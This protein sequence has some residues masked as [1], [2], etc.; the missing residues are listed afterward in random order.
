MRRRVVAIAVPAILAACG[1]PRAPA[2]PPVAI[3][4][5]ILRVESFLPRAADAAGV[6][7]AVQGLVENPNPFELSLGRIGYAFQVEGRPAGSGL[8]STSVVL[9]ARA[10]VPVQ[11]PARLR[12]ADVPGFLSLLAS[13]RTLDFHVSGAAGVR[14]QRGWIDLPY[15]MDGQVALPLL[16]EVALEG[17]SLRRS[18]VFET[19]VEVRVGIENPNEFALPTGRLAYDLSVNGVSVASAASHSLGSVPGH[20]QTTVVIPVRFSTVGAAAGMLSGALGGRAEVVLTGRAG[21]G[22]L[23]AVLDAR[24]PLAR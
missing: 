15:A 22:A 3:D 16:P 7:L 20:G 21:Y 8:L 23:E 9:P 12:W 13:R 4:P 24:T 1:G 10:A 19:V 14:T 5:P 18:N 6:T 17:A 2:P 11:I